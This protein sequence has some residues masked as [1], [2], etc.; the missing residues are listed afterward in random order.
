MSR[1]TPRSMVLLRNTTWFALPNPPPTT[2]QDVGARYVS[3]SR[4][5]QGVS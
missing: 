4:V 5:V 1:L 2:P 3:D